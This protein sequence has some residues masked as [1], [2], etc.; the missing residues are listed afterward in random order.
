MYID[1]D[2]SDVNW[3]NHSDWRTKSKV[4][5]KCA[6]GVTDTDISESDG[7]GGND[8]AGLIIL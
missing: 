4:K 6:G 8:S 5:K 1:E 3:Y 2:L 7:D